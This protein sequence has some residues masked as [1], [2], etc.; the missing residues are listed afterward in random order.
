MPGTL[1]ASPAGSDA[2]QPQNVGPVG[3]VDGTWGPYLPPF[4]DRWGQTM[5][6]KGNGM[7]RSEATEQ[8]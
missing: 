2:L 3:G 8:Q 7:E 4:F 5:D 1:S 6:L